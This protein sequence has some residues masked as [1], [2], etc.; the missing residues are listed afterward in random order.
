LPEGLKDQLRL[1]EEAERLVVLYM[2]CISDC[3]LHVYLTMLAFVPKDSAI[4]RTFKHLSFGT[5]ITHPDLVEYQPT[6]RRG[7]DLHNSIHSIAFSPDGNLIATASASLGVQVWNTITGGNVATLGDHSSTSLLVR[8]SPSGL[9]LAVAFEGGTVTIW[10]PKVGRKH[11]QDDSCHT[12]KITCLEFSE[13]SALLASGSRDHTIC[14][15]SVETAQ[16]LYHL[17]THEKP[18]TAL[19]FSNDSLRLF[20]GAED[21]LIIVWDMSTGKVIRGMMGHRKVVNCL[22]V[23]KDGKIA[24]SGSED[25]T[26]KMW[27]VGS[28]KCT[29]TISKHHTGIR[30]V[31]FFDEDKFLITACNDA[32]LS[33][34]LALR[35]TSDTIWDLEQTFRKA[36]KRAPAWQPKMMGWGV[37]TNTRT[38]IRDARVVGQ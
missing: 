35:N 6:V 1:I 20:S 21:N 3:P 17:V 30:S 28:G 33:W 4:Y 8:F 24:A 16:S 14:V 18:V 31:H 38:W 2:D 13:N 32:I 26:I 34:N 5:L 12:E 25:K 19:V 15:W 9:F 22:A 11:M 7:L 37:L 27:D 36:L 10:D 23:S 29:K